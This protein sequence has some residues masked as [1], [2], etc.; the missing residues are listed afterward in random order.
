MFLT[1]FKPNQKVDKSA[2]YQHFV[3]NLKNLENTAVEK[4][5]K[6]YQT[7]RVTDQNHMVNHQEIIENQPDLTVIKSL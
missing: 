2:C 7:G 4:L 1:T 3:N 6:S 5:G